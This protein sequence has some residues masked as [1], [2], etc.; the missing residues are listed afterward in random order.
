MVAVCVRLGHPN[1][2]VRLPTPQEKV[3]RAKQK[4]G[5]PWVNSGNLAGSPLTSANYCR[6]VLTPLAEMGN[7]MG[8]GRRRSPRSPVRLVHDKDSVHTSV[9]TTKFAARH[10]IELIE[11]PARSPDLDPLDYG[12]FGAVKRD[13][14]KRVFRERLDWDAQCA[15]FIQMLLDADATTAIEGLPARIQKCIDAGGAHFEH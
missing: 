15:S 5:S 7:K 14:Q 10:C 11:L 8:A 6:L 1:L 9:Q 2:V 12:L 3:A 13:W 4:R